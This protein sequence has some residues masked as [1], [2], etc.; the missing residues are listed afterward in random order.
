MKKY[1]HHKK[2]KRIKDLKSWIKPI[3]AR[4]YRLENIREIIP[5]EI[6]QLNSEI[7]KERLKVLEFYRLYCELEMPTTFN[8]QFIEQNKFLTIGEAE[9][10]TPILITNAISPG[11][12]S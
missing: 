7:E 9:L 4:I 2:K 5:K 12:S 10:Y 1:T 11:S 6:E 3:E 8:G